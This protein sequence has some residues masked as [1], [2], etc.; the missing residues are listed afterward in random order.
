M[1]ERVTFRGSTGPNLVGTIDVPEGPVR[2]W[3]VFA[4]GFTLGK[5]CPAAARICKQLAT[6]GIGMLRFDALG[7]GG[8][9]GDWGDGSFTVKVDDIVKACEFM[10]NDRGTP[11]DILV[12]HSWGGAAVIAAAR[13]SPGVRSVVS[14]A[15]PID[16][17]HVEKHYDSVLDCVLSEGSAE[18]MVGGRTLTLKRSF[19]E[20]V[21]VA[22]L[23]DKI[24]GLHLPLL[25]LHS[26]TDNTVGIENASEIFRL[27]RHPRSFVS[28]EGSD[29]LLTKR[30]QAHRAGRIIGAWADAYLGDP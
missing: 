12:G 18:W 28:L 24:K 4:H 30:G 23:H 20:D 10:A 16:P 13:Q 2:G 27:A 3:G 22:H 19:V 14:V 25:I 29:H 1:A 6:D 8:S 17:S 15:A 5:D 11:A 21:R 9:E 7:L 26:P